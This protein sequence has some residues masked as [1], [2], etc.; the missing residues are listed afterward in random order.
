M[1]E[2]FCVRVEITQHKTGQHS[3]DSFGI[4][5]S[6]VTYV[7]SVLRNEHETNQSIEQS[8][9]EEGFIFSA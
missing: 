2:L 4:G 8:E 5:R 3:D 6:P 1:L 9:T 7:T